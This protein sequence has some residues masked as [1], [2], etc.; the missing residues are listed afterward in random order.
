MKKKV[1]RASSKIQAQYDG[2]N[3][4]PITP[5]DLS[6]FLAFA[7]SLPLL[8]TKPKT[9]IDDNGKE[10]IIRVKN[11]CRVR[12]KHGILY[13]TVGSHGIVKKFSMC[14][15]NGVLYIDGNRVGKRKTK[16]FNSFFGGDIEDQPTKFWE[17]MQRTCF[18][19]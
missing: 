4:Y 6:K 13:E 8:N 5:D 14:T 11:G 15:A 2:M 19:I 18:G 9:I 16:E 12:N 3:V 1:N 7:D 10:V 17:R